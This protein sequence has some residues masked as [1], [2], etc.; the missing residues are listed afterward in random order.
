[1]NIIKPKL[2]HIFGQTP[3]HYLPMH[4][5]FKQVGS[6]QSIE[7]DFWAWETDST[8]ELPGFALYSDA[9][10][11]LVLMRG[12]QADTKFIFHGMFDRHLWPRLF[13]S[14]M[15]KR[16]S[17]VCWGAEL[18][19]HIGDNKT[20]RRK[21]AHMF[22]R[23]LL[24]RFCKL[25]ALNDGDGHLIR[26][27]ISAR[28]V[29]SLPYPLI[30]S[31]VEI[32]SKVSEQ[33]NILIGN[34]ANPTNEHIQVLKWLEKFSAQS[35]KIVVPLNYAGSKEYIEKVVEYGINHFGNKFEAITTM[36]E[37]DEYDHLLANTDIAIFAHHR[38]QGLYVVYS[39]LK[40]GK[41]MFM[42][43]G[44]SSYRSLQQQGFTVFDNMEIADMSFDDLI[45]DNQQVTNKN[46][47][48]MNDVFSEKALLPKWRNEL[49]ALLGLTD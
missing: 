13:L 2:V 31:N 46:P 22:H 47:E 30:G 33:K 41:K 7:Q 24:K 17:W 16:C 20:I 44:I 14:T 3:H 8:K 45:A 23:V 26:E 6:E 42:N 12:Q 10:E 11:L 25:Y 40:Y 32:E 49:L 5:F 15:P 37:K 1:M 48:L 35:I 4:T 18:Y 19:E 9:S 36:M 39:M 34:S 28:D 38:Q 43:S 29:T 27:Y 21:I